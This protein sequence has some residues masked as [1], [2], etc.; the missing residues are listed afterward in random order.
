MTI[1]E[2]IHSSCS[3]FH[4]S[5][6]LQPIYLNLTNAKRPSIHTLDDKMDGCSIGKNLEGTGYGLTI[7]HPGIIPRQNPNNHGNTCVRIAGARPRFETKT[8]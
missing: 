3:A 7:V 8:S 5:A 2:I 4:G 6:C 1:I